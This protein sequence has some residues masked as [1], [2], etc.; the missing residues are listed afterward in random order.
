MPFLPQ[1]LEV[2]INLMKDSSVQVKDTAA[3]TIGRIC[4][5]HIT[6][7]TQE[8]WVRM[9]R[10]LQPG[11]PPEAEG[12]LLAGLKDD[13]RVANNVCWAFHNLAEHCEETRND[14][15][16]VLSPLFV[17]LA[18]AL[19]HCTE[20]PDAG[21]N[22]LRCSAYEA[23]NT[24]LTNSAEDAKKNIEQ[25]LPVIIGR[26]EATFQMPVVSNDDREVVNELQGL[27]CGSLQVVT[28]K[29]GPL[30]VPHA[31]KLMQLLLQV[32]GA[33]NSTV[34][35]EALMAVGAI[36]NAT[37]AAFENYMPHFR[38]FLSLGLSNCEEH[39]VCA[40]AVGVVGDICRALE[41]KVSPYCDE[42]VAL[43]LRN[44][45]N[46]SLNRNV[47]PPILCCFGDIALAIGGHFEKYLQVTM[48]MLSQ[49]AQTQIDEN[50]PDLVDYLHQLR[51][52]IFEA[53]T[54]VLQGLRADGKQECFLPYYEGALLLV[55]QVSDP[56]SRNE[57][58]IDDL[59]RAAVG[60]VGDLAMTL[61]PSFKQIARQA[62]HKDYIRVLMREAKT[63][64]VE[65]TRQVGKWAH[66]TV[67][68]A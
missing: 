11:E 32:F 50:N 48:N 66:Q 56:A 12:V 23:L 55:Q 17:T 6:S 33:K 29:L 59:V 27:L 28:Q 1:A 21:E 63:S 2:M 34:H 3:W 15:T 4:E 10:N 25:M 35:E 41:A 58:S 43:L 46:P 39:Q 45:Q 31:D 53:Y 51:E 62:P 57:S 42:I 19:L 8:L 9:T 44:L 36:A 14:A 16:N 37:E 47:K 54:G 68:G 61:G 30:A 60:V 64:K 24:L 49:A 38:P 5:R 26:L 20:R 13:P 67:F 7:I 40:V 52:G 18:T 22:N 65:S